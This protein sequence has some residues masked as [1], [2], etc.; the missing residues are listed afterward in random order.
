V[1]ADEALEE[2]NLF[3]EGGARLL[4]RAVR[5]EAV[6]RRPHEDA[7]ACGDVGTVEADGETVFGLWLPSLL[8]GKASVHGNADV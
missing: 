3:F 6:R 2:K 1:R 4:Q 5:E 7:A 8:L